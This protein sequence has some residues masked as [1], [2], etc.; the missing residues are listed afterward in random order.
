[1]LVFSHRSVQGSSNLADCL[2]DYTRLEVLTD[3]ICRKCSLLATHKRLLLEAEKL[4]E[5]KKPD[6]SPS[7]AKKKRAREARR[8][9]AQVKA[10]LDEGRIEDDLEGIKL[11]KVHSKASTKQAMIARVSHQT[12]VRVWHLIV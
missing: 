8:M 5:V 12:L 3:C 9:A 4:S 7:T 1:M 11:E 2:T 10:A 6:S